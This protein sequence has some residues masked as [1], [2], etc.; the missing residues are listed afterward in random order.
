MKTKIC[1]CYLL[2]LLVLAVSWRSE[3]MQ[4][5]RKRLRILDELDRSG[6]M[7]GEQ[8]HSLVEEI[9]QQ[10]S[11]KAVSFPLILS[12]S[13]FH[14]LIRITH[15]SLSLFLINKANYMPFLFPTQLRSRRQSGNGLPTP[16]GDYLFSGDSNPYARIYYSGNSSPVSWPPCVYMKTILNETPLKA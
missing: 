10:V 13:L 12:L 4:N 11:H 3:G 9:A 16:H 15:Y 14:S 2:A 8:K 7:M 1:W 6:L 5:K